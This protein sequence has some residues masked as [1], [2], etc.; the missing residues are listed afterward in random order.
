VRREED[1]KEGRIWR[2]EGGGTR[3]MWSV[4]VLREY[5]LT[6]RLTHSRGRVVG[7]KRV[8]RWVDAGWVT[9]I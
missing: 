1:G 5:T 9:K 4:T 8:Q 6:G 2:G 3:D 7:P